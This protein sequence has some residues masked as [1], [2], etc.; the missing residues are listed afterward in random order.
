MEVCVCV[1]A[2]VHVRE[3]VYAFITPKIQ[4]EK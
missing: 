3:C 1:F 2:F 4:L